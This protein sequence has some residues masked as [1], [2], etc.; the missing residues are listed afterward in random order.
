MSNVMLIEWLY[1]KQ[2][3]PLLTG[4]DNWTDAFETQ[5]FSTTILLQCKNNFP[6]FDVEMAA[7]D[8]NRIFFLLELK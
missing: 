1:W 2:F 6:R 3:D 8:L 7:K 4:T 5:L